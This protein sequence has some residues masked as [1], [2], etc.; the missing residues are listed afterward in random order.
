M[1]IYR[2]HFNRFH[3]LQS[4]SKN[5]SLSQYLVILFAPLLPCLAI[6][7]FPCPPHRTNMLKT[8]E[9]GTLCLI[10]PL[11][12]WPQLRRMVSLYP[13]PTTGFSLLFWET[14]VTGVIWLLAFCILHVE[15]LHLIFWDISDLYSLWDR[16]RLI[17]INILHA[18]LYKAFEN[19]LM[20][21]QGGVCQP[22]E[23]IPPS[24]KRGQGC[25]RWASWWGWRWRGWNM[26]SVLMR[27]GHRLGG[28]VTS[29]V[30]WSM[31]FKCF[32]KAFLVPVV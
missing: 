24:P 7:F 21:I 28:P 30:C 22:G 13:D 25:R 15:I 14:R 10:W 8:E 27:S 11:R 4:P 31:F 12:I 5:T 29:L 18:H 3:F 9:S 6:Q 17:Y 2:I 1:H 16:Y 26:P 23:I 19:L 32:S 20:H